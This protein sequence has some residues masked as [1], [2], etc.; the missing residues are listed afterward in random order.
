MKIDFD[1]KMFFDRNHFFVIVPYYEQ[2]ENS[3]NFTDIS[4]A[5]SFVILGHFFENVAKF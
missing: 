3:K 1:K 4:K 5:G 2:Y